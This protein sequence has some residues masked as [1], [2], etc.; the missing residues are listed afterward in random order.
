MTDD[1]PVR[2]LAAIAKVERAA[3]L[4]D[5]FMVPG[6]CRAHREIVELAMVCRVDYGLAL[7]KRARWTG[8]DDY[9]HAAPSSPPMPA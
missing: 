5:A 3:H 4:T 1:L 2:L 7:E 9:T 6:F 8:R